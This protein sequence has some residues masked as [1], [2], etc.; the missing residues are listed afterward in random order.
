MTELMGGFAIPHFLKVQRR[1][2]RYLPAAGF[3]PKSRY[4][5]YS[6]V[7]DYYKTAQPTGWDLTQDPAPKEQSYCEKK[8][9]QILRAGITEL[10]AALSPE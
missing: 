9:I 2:K 3:A 1:G 10:L 5:T 8:G 4:R 7:R 6:A